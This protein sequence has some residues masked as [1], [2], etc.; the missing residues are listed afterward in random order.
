M[1][2]LPPTP[3]H[4]LEV[5]SGQR[6]A[7]GEN[8]RGFIDS[9][10]EGRI[11]LATESLARLL[12]PDRVRGRSF[13]DVGSGSGL[14][15]LAALRLGAARVHSFD[16]DT[17]S[18]ASTR[19]LRRRVAPDATAWTVQE[20]SVLDRGF[21]G[22]LGTFDV[23]YSW[24]V[25][26]HTGSMWEAL[27][28][29]ASLV[30]PGGTLCVALYNDQGRASRVWVRIKRAYNAAPRPVRPLLVLAYATYGELRSVV[31]RWRRGMTVNP[32]RHWAEYR[33]QRGMSVWHDY[34]DWIGGYPFEVA[35]PA[36]VRE[37]YVARGFDPVHETTVGMD[38]GCNEFVFT[39]RPGTDQR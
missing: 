28:N 15:S 6:F 32:V 37:F 13:L 21:L 11:T 9:I 36:A 3:S 19:E 38:L 17:D 25:L 20:G 14:S 26:H 1:S 23:V 34:V 7:F 24:G 16:Y 39:R 4:R 10:D 29:V 22:S 18:V 33:A 31:G 2:I 8:W 35:T 5:D 12:G 30:A 27:D